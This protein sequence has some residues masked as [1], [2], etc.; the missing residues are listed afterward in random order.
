MCMAETQTGDGEPLHISVDLQD[1]TDA[2]PC[3]VLK[4]LRKFAGGGRGGGE[5]RVDVGVSVQA[6]KGLE[7]LQVVYRNS[8]SKLGS[9]CL[10]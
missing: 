7:E 10:G 2:L 6:L 9:S 3:T 8:S 5:L 1:L 4:G